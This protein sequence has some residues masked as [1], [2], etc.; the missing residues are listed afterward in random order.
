MVQAVEETRLKSDEVRLWTASLPAMVLPFFAS[1][2]Y[3]V[4]LSDHWISRVIYTAT[5]MFT[6]VWP[7]IA[8]CFILQPRNSPLRGLSLNFELKS[9]CLGAATGALIVGL[10]FGLMTGPIGEII[11]SGTSQ[12]RNKAAA[13]GILDHYWAFGLFLALIHSWIEEYYWRWFVYGR[14]RELLRPALAHLLA[15]LSFAA[16]HVVIAT[17]FFDGA[18]GFILGGLVGVGGIIWSLLY[19]RQQNLIGVWCSHA[20]VDLGI[21]AI[22]HKLL[23]GS[24]F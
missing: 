10:M 21:L 12:I 13:L 14:L 20:I 3:F 19:E 18:W 1:L 9:W 23:F 4:L 8:L 15:G 5:K 16:H 11:A 2:L 22:G 24:Y 17:Q 6:L 7:V